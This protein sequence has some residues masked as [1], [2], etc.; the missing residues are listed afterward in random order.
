M[1]ITAVA[2]SL[3]VSGYPVSRRPDPASRCPRAKSATRDQMAK[4][5]HLPADE[6]KALA[7][8]DLG[9]FYGHPRKEYE[10][11]VGNAVWGQKGHPWRP[12]FLALQKGRTQAPDEGRHFG[13][14][15]EDKEAA[16]EALIAA[17]P[18][19]SSQF[20]GTATEISPTSY[21]AFEIA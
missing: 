2:D 21:S 18:G 17:D 5:L 7:S 4:V 15:V 19:P 3:A 1:V 20:S 9:R 11:A 6:A 14:V 8:G 10:L 16:R 13:L 12:E